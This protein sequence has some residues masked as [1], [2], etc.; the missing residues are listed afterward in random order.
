MMSSVKSLQGTVKRVSI[1]V[2]VSKQ[3]VLPYS[4]VAEQKC[5]VFAARKVCHCDVTSSY[6]IWILVFED[7]FPDRF[8]EGTARSPPPQKDGQHSIEDLRLQLPS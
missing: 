4:L 1:S 8:C 7:Q 3:C 2:Y 5:V 6:S